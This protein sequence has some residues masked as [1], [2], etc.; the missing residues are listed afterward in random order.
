MAVDDLQV[1]PPAIRHFVFL[2]LRV[3]RN[4]MRWQGSAGTRRLITMIIGI[5]VG[6]W[7]AIGGFALFGF[8]S[9]SGNT[10]LRTGLVCLTGGAVTLGWLL[11]PLLFFGVDETIDPARFA[12]LPIPRRILTAGMLAA[13]CVG[14]PAIVTAIATLGL[15]VGAFLRGGIGAGLVALVAVP[16]ILLLCVVGS[17]AMTSAFASMLRSRKMRDLAV[18]LI[19]L[20]AG[21]LGPLQLALMSV[22]EKKGSGV[23][24]DIA[25]VVGWTPLAAAHAAVLDAIDGRWSL[26][27]VRLAIVIVTIGLLGRWWAATLESA[28]VGMESAG[29]ADRKA[30]VGGAVR[31]LVPPV[32]RALP[33]SA[34]VAIVAR[35]LRYFWRDPRWRAS[36]ASMVIASVFLPVALIAMPG[37]GGQPASLPTVALFVGIVM[38]LSLVNIF[39]YDGPAYALHVLTGVRG[40]TELRARATGLTILVIPLLLVTGLAVG[41]SGG[42]VG[43]VLPTLG[44]AAAAFGAATTVAMFVAV[45]VPYPM[46]QA[47]NP[48]AVSS[49][50]ATVRSLATFGGI[51]CAVA[52]ASPVIV[53]SF[54]LPDS[55][56]WLLLPLGIGW[57]VGSILIG[58]YIAGDLLDKRGPEVL[59]AVTPRN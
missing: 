11:L 34:F 21:S 55:W 4:G 9:S 1:R 51:A 32:L 2:K 47:G 39:G 49:G 14:I 24:T 41:I 29:P 3:L 43:I 46:P 50:G 31:G 30:A 19:V 57:S 12:L 5:L 10:D 45:L 44:M 13:A 8:G 40:T 18:I 17:R 59:Q 52:V 53:A 6:L 15:V 26:V 22:I 23:V 28:M 37:D 33:D 38:G 48:F 20:L 58:A 25:S 36:I 35:D 56:D 27:P 54:L 42:E 7:A 16:L